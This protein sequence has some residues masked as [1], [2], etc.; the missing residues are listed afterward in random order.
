MSPVTT[1]QSHYGHDDHGDHKPNFWVRWFYSTNHK[2][3][4]TLYLIRRSCPA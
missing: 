3:I 4:G 2:D 1:S